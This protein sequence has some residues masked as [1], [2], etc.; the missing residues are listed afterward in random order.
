[1][2]SETAEAAARVIKD[3]LRETFKTFGTRQL[4]VYQ[5]IIERGIEMVAAD[6]DRLGSLDRTELVPGV[7]LFHLELTTSRRG[8]AA[9]CLYYTTGR[10]SDGSIGTI[11][12]RVLHEH[13]ERRHKVVRSLEGFARGMSGQAEEPSS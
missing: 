5:Q 6:P 13:M 3:I 2:S 11:I 10:V 12:L 7:K 1:M 9:H 8:G 4:T